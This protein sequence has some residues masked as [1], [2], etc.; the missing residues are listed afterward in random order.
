VRRS[1]PRIT[2]TESKRPRCAKCTKRVLNSGIPGCPQIEDTHWE[3][4]KLESND[5]RRV[6]ISEV[7]SNNM[8]RQ[9]RVIGNQ[10]FHLS[11]FCVYRIELFW[12]RNEWQWTLNI[13]RLIQTGAASSQPPC[14][15][16]VPPSLSLC[17]QSCFPDLILIPLLQTRALNQNC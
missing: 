4:R 11:G 7:P 10:E 13:E 17:G 2:S 9:I 8:L 12:G 16:M 1:N 15:T 6:A 14:T 3:L 5:M